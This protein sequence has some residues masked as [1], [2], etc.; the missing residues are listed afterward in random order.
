MQMAESKWLQACNGWNCSISARVASCAQH[1]AIYINP[2]IPKM[3][4][5]QWV[6]QFKSIKPAGM[7][8]NNTICRPIAASTALAFNGVH[9]YF[10]PAKY[11]IY[12]ALFQ[13]NY[14]FAHQWASDNIVAVSSFKQNNM[15][16]K[17]HSD[18]LGTTF[19]VI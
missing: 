1:N 7:D 9:Q 14:L 16:L 19:Q 5:F 10:I 11:S 18:Q 6:G 3:D 8:G 17:C 13:C 2:S 15:V 4:A 12:P